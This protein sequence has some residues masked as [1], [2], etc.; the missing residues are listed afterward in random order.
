MGDDAGEDGGVS[1]CFEF[2]LRVTIWFRKRE[3]SGEVFFPS[4]FLFLLH[5]PERRR[6]A[7]W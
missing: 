6:R 5:R 4:L 1:F 2:E 7:G 3:V